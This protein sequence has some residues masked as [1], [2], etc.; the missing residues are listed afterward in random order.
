MQ[1][2]IIPSF[3]QTNNKTGVNRTIFDVVETNA[4][5]PPPVASIPAAAAVSPFGVGYLGGLVHLDEDL[6]NLV[7][8]IYLH[9]GGLAPEMKGALHGYTQGQTVSTGR[10]DRMSHRKRRENK[11]QPSRDRSCHQI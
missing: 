6:D 2:G 3:N 5:R 7:P 11:Q 10:L 8:L 1:V 4:T 9:D